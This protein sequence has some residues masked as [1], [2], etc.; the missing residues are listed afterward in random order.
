MSGFISTGA[1]QDRDTIINTNIINTDDLQDS[2]QSRYQNR[3]NRPFAGGENC[4]PGHRTPTRSHPNK[5]PSPGPVLPL[6]EMM[7]APL[8]A[9]SKLSFFPSSF[10]CSSGPGNSLGTS[11]AGEAM[12][13]G[14]C[15]GTFPF[16][17]PLFK[18]DRTVVSCRCLFSLCFNLAQDK[19]S[20]ESALWRCTWG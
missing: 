6:D 8:P 18:D 9:L 5:P 17:C 12:A 19:T 3:Q 13:R 2:F 1:E 16:V 4:Q 10:Q 11:P 20:P 7:D 15:L 14:K